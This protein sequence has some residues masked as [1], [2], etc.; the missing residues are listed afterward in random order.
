MSVETVTDS[1]ASRDLES[2]GK[3]YK[4]PPLSHTEVQFY[5]AGSLTSHKDSL[6]SSDGDIAQKAYSRVLSACSDCFQPTRENVI[7]FEV[8]SSAETGEVAE[9]PTGQTFYANLMRKSEENEDCGEME[10][11]DRSIAH[12]QEVISQQK[13]LIQGLR[14]RPERLDKSSMT[15][16]GDSLQELEREIEHLTSA[17][18]RYER[19]NHELRTELQSCTSDLMQ[20]DQTK[21]RLQRELRKTLAKADFLE[22]NWSKLAVFVDSILSNKEEEGRLSAPEGGTELASYVCGRVEV[23]GAKYCR[24]LAAYGQFTE[25]EARKM[26]VGQRQDTPKDRSAR[27]LKDKF[28]KQ[29][30]STISAYKD[31]LL[32][33]QDQW[34]EVEA[35]PVLAQTEQLK[36]LMQGRE[37]VQPF[38]SQQGSPERLSPTSPA[39]SPEL[40][41]KSR[42]SEGDVQ[43]VDTRQS[44]LSEEGDIS[45]GQVLKPEN[46]VQT[47]RATWTAKQGQRSFQGPSVQKLVKE[48]F[49]P[50]VTKEPVKEP[51]FRIGKAEEDREKGF[52]LVQTTKLSDTQRSKGASSAVDKKRG[53]QSTSAEP[54][55]ASGTEQ[56]ARGSK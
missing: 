28:I 41:G 17:C 18:K 15:H 38:R 34:S 43:P 46:S 47:K 5:P 32:A 23:L 31:Q 19:Q 51:A 9:E 6:L 50:V 45:E 30:E 3:S 16:S 48:R 10:R 1:E 49:R 53:L 12:L 4:E 13:L 20:L 14:Q 37:D 29:L 40:A 2:T 44:R 35:Q 55:K 7:V 27:S 42:G 11:R 56:K 22:G 33:L 25:Q 21:S 52:S 26:Q 24:L 8:A 54:R 36:Y 39:R